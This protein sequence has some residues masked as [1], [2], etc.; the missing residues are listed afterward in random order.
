[1]PEAVDD[2]AVRVELGSENLN[3]S[4][5]AEWIEPVAPGPTSPLERTEI[6]V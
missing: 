2:E 5:S 3:L 1:M 6:C 4:V